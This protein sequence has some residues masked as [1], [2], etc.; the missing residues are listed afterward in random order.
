MVAPLQIG[1]GITIGGSISIGTVASGGTAGVDGCVGYDQIPGP[2]I[3]GNQIEDG[4]ATVNNPVGFTCNQLD[5]QNFTGVAVSNLTPSN[6][7]FFATYG[8]GQRTVTWGAGST[9]ATTQVNL[10]TNSGRLVFFIE[11]ISVPAT[12]N[13]PVTFL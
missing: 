11:G 4:T 6:L 2:I 3:A 13:W 1:G 5:F 8:T 7:N 10:V 9:Y 12:F